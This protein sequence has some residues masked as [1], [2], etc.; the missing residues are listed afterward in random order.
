MDKAALA[1]GLLFWG[2]D[3]EMG[4]DTKMEEV[5]TEERREWEEVQPVLEGGNSPERI[6]S[7]GV[8]GAI[9]GSR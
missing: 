1:R 5:Y 3:P 9:T 2:A 4:C 6:L 8:M 7:R